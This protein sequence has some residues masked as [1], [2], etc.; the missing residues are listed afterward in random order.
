MSCDEAVQILAARI[1]ET[2]P[3]AILRTD[4]DLTAEQVDD[5]A[6]RWRQM[7]RR[8]RGRVS[9]LAGDAAIGMVGDRPA[10]LRLPDLP[11][12]HRLA[13]PARRRLGHHVVL[14]SHLHETLTVLQRSHEQTEVTVSARGAS[15]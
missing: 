14:P 12:P 8:G 13:T 4:H 5:V 7:Q 1:A 3:T 11:R 6:E 9:V 15:S 2:F 10:R